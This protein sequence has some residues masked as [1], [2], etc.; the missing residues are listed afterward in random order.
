MHGGIAKIHTLEDCLVTP[1]TR[2]RQGYCTHK[3]QPWK[4]VPCLGER[5]QGG[6]HPRKRRP[7]IAVVNLLPL[8]YSFIP[9][10]L[11]Q[12]SHTKNCPGFTFNLR[13]AGLGMG[14]IVESTHWGDAVISPSLRQ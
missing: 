10:R 13:H 8:Y 7:E 3:R 9:T 4:Y 6:R 14:R 12:H 2:N 11:S 1:R 5:S